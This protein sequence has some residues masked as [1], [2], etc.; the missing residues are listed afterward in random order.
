VRILS[1]NQLARPNRPT[2][3]RL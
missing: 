3:R 2:V 1:R